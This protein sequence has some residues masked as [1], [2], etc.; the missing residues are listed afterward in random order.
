MKKV[1]NLSKAKVE[2]LPRETTN[3]DE[4]RESNEELADRLTKS[5][6]V[7]LMSKGSIVYG[8]GVTL[9]MALPEDRLDIPKYFTYLH[10]EGIDPAEKC[11][12]R[13]RQD[14]LSGQALYLGAMNSVI[15]EFSSPQTHIQAITDAA[16][17]RVTDID[18]CMILKK[19]GTLTISAPKAVLN[20]DLPETAQLRVRGGLVDPG[21][22]L[23]YLF[24]RMSPDYV[25]G[26]FQNYIQ[27]GIMVN[28][29]EINE[30][31]RVVHRTLKLEGDDLTPMIAL[32]DDEYVDWIDILEQTPLLRGWTY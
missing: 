11:L 4:L 26:T 25:L 2:E 13:I 22:W 15:Q 31:M 8:P 32:D 21:R 6:I 3:L 10:P 7:S 27:A 12:L 23:A 14:P 17:Y 5:H 1:L 9:L 28:A 20:G 18:S 19:D 29:S 16:I 24:A 30:V